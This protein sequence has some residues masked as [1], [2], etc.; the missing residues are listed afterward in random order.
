[1][2]GEDDP[3][4]EPVAQGAVLFSVAESR[5]HQVVFL[6]AF[7]KGCAGQGIAVVRTV[8]QLEF[9]DDVIAE[10]APP[11]VGHADALP[12]QLVVEHLLEVLVGELVDHEQAFAQAVRLLFLFA[13]FPFLDFDIVFPGQPFQGFVIVQLLVLH[14]EMDHV[15]SL[16][17][18]EAFAQSFA[19]RYAEGGRLFVVER[20]QADIVDAATAQRHKF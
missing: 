20:T 11:Q 14:D 15:A 4:P 13:Q 9:F 6:I 18:A 1:M 7:L 8:A 19:G 10:A 16:A 2:D 5:F 17:A 12:F 3:S